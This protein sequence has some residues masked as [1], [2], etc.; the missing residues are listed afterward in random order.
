MTHS[1]KF[2]A[3]DMDG[4]LLDENSNLPPAFPEFF[5]RLKNEDIL[6]AAASGRQY[7]SLYDTFAD[8]QEEMLFIAENGT[9]VMHKGNELYSC[10]LDFDAIPAIINKARTIDNAFIVLC[11]KKSAYIETQDPVALAEISKYYHRCE[12]VEDL[13]SVNDEFIKI[14]LLHFDGSA[15]HIEPVIRP[16]FEEAFQVVVSAKIWLDVMNKVA[17]K[18]AA[19]RHLQQTLEFSYEQT[20]SFGDYFNDAEMLKESYYSYAME[21][22]HP[23]VKQIARFSAPS[24]TE[25]GV[26]SAVYDFLDKK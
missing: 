5:Q 9:I 3:T 16:V 26:I 12:Y 8:Y 23:G 11:G 17:S 1:I 19:I 13:L 21:N 15:K 22:A 4:T 6:F 2:I 7:Y 25:Y 18:G 20:M 10:T 14:A 24:N